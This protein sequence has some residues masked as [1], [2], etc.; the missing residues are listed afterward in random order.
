MNSNYGWHIAETNIFWGEISPCDHVVQIYENDKTFLD[1]L[2]NYVAGGFKLNECVIVIATRQH[3]NA[4]HDRLKED[5]FNLFELMINDHYIPL[6]A[7]ET[8]GKFMVDGWPD[9][10]LF[11]YV[12]DKLVS[13]AMQKKQ[14]IR[15]FG[16]MVAILWSQGHSGATVQLEHL[17]NRFCEDKSLC[18]FCAYPKSGF[19]EDA[20]T[21]MSNIC[22]AHA[23]MIDGVGESIVI[24]KNM[25]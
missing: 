14:K 2:E 25:A 17:W 13:K 12:I 22:G 3:L 4:L 7:E 10:N 1:L 5:G 16:E 21:S 9:E 8:L 18:L 24:Y 20:S 23:R 19:T 15:A 11:K 6:D